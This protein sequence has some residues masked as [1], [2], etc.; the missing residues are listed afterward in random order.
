A[1]PFD[2]KRGRVTGA[3]VTIGTGV[4][5]TGGGF[6]QVAVAENG[7][8]AYIPEEPRSLVFVDRA[9]GFR[10]AVA[11][12][13]SYH[14]PMFS[15]DGTRLS[16]DY[17]SGDGR[18]VWTLSL[19]QGTLTRATFARDG[20]HATSTPDGRFITYASSRG[21]SLGIFRIRPGSAT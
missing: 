14:A 1:V 8:V 2:P 13:H 10:T 19:A 6:G 17:H 20:H 11:E 16:T 7:T 18:D 12:R 3:A 21:G 15:P 5:V 9:G 4:S